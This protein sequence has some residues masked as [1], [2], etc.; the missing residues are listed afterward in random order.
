M[1]YAPSSAVFFPPIPPGGTLRFL[2]LPLAL[3]FSQAALAGPTGLLNDTGQ[4]DCQDD[5]A[6]AACATVATDGGTHPRQDGRF[7][8]DAKTAAGKLAKTGG[9]AA[10]FDFTK[11]CW[12]GD[13]E[14]SGTCTGALVAN[15]T[16]TAG[17]TPSTDWACTKDN[18]TNLIWSLETVS[19]T[20]WLDAT[21]T[22]PAAANAAGRCG[23]NT[24]W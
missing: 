20:Y 18:L 15:T 16:G 17:G 6:V 13:L 5:V 9:G 24:G 23:L 4:T 1:K 2:M 21:T 11:V 10:G 7:G 14:G 22:H 12:N 19:G 8:R 3:I